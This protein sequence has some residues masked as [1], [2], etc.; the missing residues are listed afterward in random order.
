MQRG[1]RPPDRYRC[2]RRRRASPGQRRPPPGGR[3]RRSCGAR[4]LGEWCPRTCG[5]LERPGGGAGRHPLG[6]GSS[7]S[8]CPSG[9]SR[10]RRA[11]GRRR[12]GSSSRTSLAR[13]FVPRRRGR[14]PPVAA[15]GGPPCPGSRPSRGA[16]AAPGCGPPGSGRRR[17]PP[18]GERRAGGRGRRAGSRG[19]RRRLVAGRAPCGPSAGG[20]PQ[21]GLARTAARPG[22]LDLSSA[23]GC[24]RRQRPSPRR[25]RCGRRR[26][27]GGWPLS[28][29]RCP[30]LA[31]SAG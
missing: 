24:R 20:R 1:G 29:P 13:A 17:L 6:A 15:A 12:W 19:G 18:L 10:C 11:P 26:P 2:R 3:R 4:S 31:A 14:S 25:W 9:R 28:A 21:P 30:P 16:R 7:G 5:T 8:A 27:S 22:V 23:R